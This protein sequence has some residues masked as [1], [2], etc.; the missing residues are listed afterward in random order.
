MP[1]APGDV[2]AGYTVV[3]TLGAGGMGEVHL[4]RHPRLPRSDALKVLRPEHSA[5]P[6]FAA[7]F[8]READLVARLSH[9]NV[10]PCSTAARR[11]AGCG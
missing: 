9:R 7:R 3:R 8:R 6:H 1:L 4:A 10:V 5:D 11:R 2:F